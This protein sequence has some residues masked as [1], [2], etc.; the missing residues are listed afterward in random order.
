MKII[1]IYLFS[2]GSHHVYFTINF[3]SF[4]NTNFY[5]YIL[6]SGNEGKKRVRV[7]RDHSDTTHRSEYNFSVQLTINVSTITI[8]AEIKR[9]QTFVIHVKKSKNVS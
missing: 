1:D 4:N 3:L 7:Q 8:H 2:L 9:L 6:G 5:F